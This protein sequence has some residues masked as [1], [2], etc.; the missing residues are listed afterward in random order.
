MT[1][2]AEGSD[3]SAPCCLVLRGRVYGPGVLLQLWQS[4]ASSP[5]W[6]HGAILSTPSSGNSRKHVPFCGCNLLSPKIHI[7]ISFPC[8]VKRES[9]ICDSCILF[10]AV[11]LN[12][13]K[14]PWKS[15]SPKL[16]PNFSPHGKEIMAWAKP[17]HRGVLWLQCLQVLWSL[18]YG[19][20]NVLLLHPKLKVK[21]VEI[22]PCL[23]AW[24]RFTEELLVIH[25]FTQ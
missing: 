20:D 10:S 2:C 21:V 1:L 12:V 7:I 22:S 9:R 4:R 17:S 19:K 16:W 23:T 11:P 25:F 5:T 18:S 15:V 24:I 8:A 6:F 14:K 3:F 13:L